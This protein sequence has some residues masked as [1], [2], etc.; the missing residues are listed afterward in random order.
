M[1]NDR[2]VVFAFDLGKGSLGEAVR[3][4]KE[5][6][7]AESFLFPND[8]AS[9]KDQ[10]SRR[11][12]KRTR[13]AHKAREEWLKQQCREA[14][15]EVLEGRTTGNGSKGIPVR[16]HG[17]PRL[18]REFA[19]ANDPTCYTSCLLRIKLLRGEKL[20]GWQVYKALHSA[21]QRRGYE[22]VPWAAREANRSGA[23]KDDD[24]KKNESRLSE[25]EALFASMAPDREDRKYLCYFDA[26]KMGLWNPVTDEVQPRITNAAG[27]ARNYLI[28]RSLVEKELH[29]LLE[30]A[31]A[32]FPKLKGKA[33]FIMYG[34]AGTPYASYYANLRAKY[35]LKRGATTDWQG[36]LSQKIP[37][38]DNRIIAHCALIPRFNVCRS[39]DPVTWQATFLMSLHRMRYYVDG[40]EKRLTIEEIRELFAAA[41]KDDVKRKAKDKARPDAETKP[42]TRPKAWAMT[43]SAWEKWCE[44][45][46]GKPVAT[47]AEVEAP[48]AAGRSRFS[49]PALRVLRD[50]ILSGESPHAF[51]K[52]LVTALPEGMVAS[53][54]DFLLRMPDDWARIHIPDDRSSF[55]GLNREERLS[56]I[57]ALIGEQR[58]P[59]VRHRLGVFQQRLEV[60]EHKW[61]QPDAVA[62]EFVREDFMGEKARKR[63]EDFQKKRREE[64]KRAREQAIELT[65]D[66]G[67]GAMLRM[68][69]LRQQSGRCLYTGEALGETEILNYHID[70]IVPRGSRYSGSDAMFNKVLTTEAAN[71]DKGERTPY[72]WLHGAGEWQAY[73][74]RVNDSAGNLG[75][76]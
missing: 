50:L 60:L 59:V 27:R 46:G 65:G 25:F 10:T 63:L 14:G 69:L 73:V 39:D 75:R 3:K 51:H 45:H 36:A 67:G 8:F 24:E 43:K 26:W 1:K 32:Q 33:D 57:R 2:G 74:Q 13:E 29:A 71:K 4:D 64:R 30:K 5:I 7:H 11:R 37:R 52:R 68:E 41:Q 61:G 56:R 53:D 47:Q 21:I 40:H 18:E 54:L 17:D 31:A 15:I 38:F 58:D 35:G 34:P 70:H 23:K 6:V 72:E 20:E 22:G 42:T 28:P 66:A 55:S 49:R 44:R 19:P 9:T 16:E 12:A 76:K 62:I 48:R